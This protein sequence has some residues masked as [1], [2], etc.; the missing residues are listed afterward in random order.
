MNEKNSGDLTKQIL[1]S[2]LKVEPEAEELLES[3]AMKTY[4]NFAIAVA[5]CPGPISSQSRKALIRY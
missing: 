1:I 4:M 5:S 2:D 3:A